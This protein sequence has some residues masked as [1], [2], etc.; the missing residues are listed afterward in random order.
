MLAATFCLFD[1]MLR[2]MA[3]IFADGIASHARG[4]VS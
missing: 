2:G 1:F 3:E 4:F